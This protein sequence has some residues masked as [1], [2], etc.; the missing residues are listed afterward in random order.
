MTSRDFFEWQ[1]S[2]GAGDV[3]RL[4]DT[5]ESRQIP[6]CMIGGLAVNHWAAEPLVTRDVDIVITAQRLEEAVAALEAA[7]FTAQRH[8]WS[9]NL[10]GTGAVTIQITTEGD[11]AD[12]PQRAVAADVHGIL[13]RVASREDTLTGKVRAWSDVQRRPSKRQK[14]L[15]DIT[16]LVEAYPALWDR[17]PTE[18]QKVV[19]RT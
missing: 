1:T 7:G 19:P 6:W 10:Q 15:L 5:L 4:V 18:L 16:R 8:E 12:F 2:G 3:R 14:D 9:I 17:L 11:Y 13:M